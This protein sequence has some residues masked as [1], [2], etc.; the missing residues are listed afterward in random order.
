MLSDDELRALLHGGE[1]DHVER[2]VSLRDRS[3]F[4]EAICAFANDLVDRR[5][6]GVL[7]V[8]VADDGRCGD[9]TIDE[10]LLQTLMGFRS[11][12]NILPP[13]VMQVRRHTLDG[14]TMAI[15]EVQPAENPPI[16]YDGRVCVRIGPR[17]G[18]A[19]AEEER[20]LVEK[21]RWGALAFDQQPIAGASVVDLD[22]LRFREE[23]LPT[24]VH[25][26]VLAENGRTVEE[27]M[28]ALGIIGPEGR[29]TALGLLVCGKDPRAW[30]PG[31]YVQF[32]RYPGAEVGEWVQDQKEIGGPLAA[33]LRQIDEVI[34]ANIE[35]AADL[36][37]PI[38]Q[39]R[40]S[41][42]AIAL[43]ELVRNAVIHRTY[44]GT[45]APVMLTWYADRV[46]I[47][48]PGGP[49]GAVTAQTFGQPGLTDARNPALA[50][51]AKA[52]GFV[53]R[54]GS[55]IPR[56]RAALE[57]NGNPPPEFR[58]EPNFVHVTV[59]VVP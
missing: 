30:L 12:G 53:Q 49:Y 32:V 54:F 42:P 51:A 28:R 33:M 29:P 58:V 9:L 19:T 56:A 22:L 35:R 3:K 7:F 34:A 20:R 59:R 14:C 43:R 39:V 37:G 26:D 23:Y 38:E 27:Q 11:D 1:A 21:R 45:A 40:A 36:S 55:G 48:S 25:P 52:M 6:P 8:G 44:E 31:A 13:P 10:Q 17:R 41:Y 15:V 57:R 24:V 5:M 50:A 16:K 18:Y 4:G 47:T 2:T 46:E